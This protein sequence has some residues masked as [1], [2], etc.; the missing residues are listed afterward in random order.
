MLELDKIIA[1]LA[2]GMDSKSVDDH[3][4]HYKGH[5]KD[6]HRV[7]LEI[8]SKSMLDEVAPNHLS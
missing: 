6:Q 8:S 4:Q 2:S 3:S 5:V 7:G 1:E